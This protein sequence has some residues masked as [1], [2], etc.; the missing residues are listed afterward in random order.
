MVGHQMG[1]QGVG[2][3][4][5]VRFVGVSNHSIDRKG[6]VVGRE[7]MELFNKVFMGSLL[8]QLDILYSAV[9]AVACKLSI[10]DYS[11]VK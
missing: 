10:V 2:A 5:S 4:A 9:T 3:T 11:K 7:R 8:E 6:R 1:G